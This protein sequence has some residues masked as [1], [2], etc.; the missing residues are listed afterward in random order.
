MKIGKPQ[1]ILDP[2][3][4]LPSDGE[5]RVSFRSIGA[6]VILEVEYEKDS[7]S[8]SDDENL[9]ICRR[10]LV[11][12]FARYFIKT[13]FPGGVFFEYDESSSKP[14]IGGLTEFLD[15]AFA[16]TGIDAYQS[17]YGGN[18]PK[19]RHF[20]IQFMSANVGFHVLAEEVFLSEELSVN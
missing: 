1:L 12:K 9:S 18:A 14:S 4:W 5:S 8:S 7:S 15:S 19:M 6:D 17:M 11:F 20:S 16:K 2:Y 13:P 10:E 3:E